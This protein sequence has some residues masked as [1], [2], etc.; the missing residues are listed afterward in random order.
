M[1]NLLISVRNIT[2]TIS[3]EFVITAVFMKAISW[4]KTKNNLN[5]YNICV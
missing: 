5:S 4:S 3:Y 2:I 1:F